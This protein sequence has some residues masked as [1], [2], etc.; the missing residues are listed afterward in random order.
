[1]M[2]VFIWVQVNQSFS[3]PCPSW[4]PLGRHNKW[5]WMVYYEE[6]INMAQTAVMQLAIMRIIIM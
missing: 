4:D 6:S 2:S 3:M 1:M 5:V